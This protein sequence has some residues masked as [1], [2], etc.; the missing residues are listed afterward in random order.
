MSFFKFEPEDI[1]QSEILA[2]PSYTVSLKN[3]AVTG[4]IYLERPFIEEDLKA[5]LFRGFSEKEGGIVEKYSPFT[6][7]VDIF[8]AES[9]ATNEELYG[10]I[11]ELYNYYKLINSDYTSNFTGS[12]TT[13]F[14]VMTIPEI[15]YDRQILTGSFSASDTDAAGDARVLFDNGRGGIYSGSL[16]G[17]LVGNIFYSKGLVVLKGGGLNNESVQVG[18]DPS[19][20]NDFGEASPTAYKWE[21]SFKGTHKIPVK[22]FRCR[23][24]AGQLNAS[25]NETF[26]H[27]PS[28]SSVDYK[29]EK[30]RVLSGS[31]TFITTVGLYNDQ[32]ELV[33]KARVAQPVKKNET[34]ALLFRLKMDF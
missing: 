30:V 9:G 19:T 25:T 15:Y 4:S 1:I 29:G 3:D 8:D 16:T 7:S 17:T 6:A 31:E 18:E 32:F 24:P 23:A 10:S 5:R 2:H 22:I 12:T 11:L 34:D 27:I 14:R 21:T 20:S 13:R 28:G 26:Y 33:A